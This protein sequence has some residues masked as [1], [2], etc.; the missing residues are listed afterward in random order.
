MCKDAHSW[1]ASVPPRQG[2]RVD[3]AITSFH[4]NLIF[5]K[6][7]KVM[8]N[9]DVAHYRGQLA[10]TLPTFLLRKNSQFKNWRRTPVNLQYLYYELL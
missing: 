5:V 1:T 10:T 3:K 8:G 7:R 6:T 2:W 9:T 4:K